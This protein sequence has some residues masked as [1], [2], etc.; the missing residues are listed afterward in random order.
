MASRPIEPTEALNAAA[1][2][3]IPKLSIPTALV[4]SEHV[5]NLIDVR[6]DEAASDLGL[7]LLTA[8]YAA[9]IEGHA[10]YANVSLL[11]ELTGRTNLNSI[12]NSIYTLAQAGFLTLTNDGRIVLPIVRNEALRYGKMIVGGKRGGRPKGK[13][14]RRWEQ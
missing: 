1:Y 13:C 10:P 4:E 11:S 9:Q 8:C 12:E 3:A 7:W 5:R 2:S 14:G 6:G